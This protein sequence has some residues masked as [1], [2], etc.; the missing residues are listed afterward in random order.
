METNNHPLVSV[1]IITYNSSETIIE[2]LESIKAQSYQNIELIISDDCSKDNTVEICQEWVEENKDRFVRTQIITVDQNTGVSTNLNRAEVACQGDWVKSIAGDDL[3]LPICIETYVEYVKKNPNVIYVFSKVEVFGG[4]EERRQR[5]IELG[6]YDFFS[7]SSEQQ[8][9]YLT[10]NRNCIYA[11]TAFY[12]RRRVDE[13]GI[14]NDERIPLLEDWP[15]WIR[16][17]QMGIKLHFIDEVLVK[18]RMSDNA[19]STSTHST[20]FMKSNALVYK[21]YC[22]KNDLKK[23]NKK[24]AVLRYLRGERFLHDNNLFWKIICKLYKILII[25]SW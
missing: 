13:L 23:G 16:L 3:L 1:P 11:M 4:T 25:H 8:Y 15:K 9:D 6:N 24:M 21:Y 10:L 18:Y 14:T 7:W 20:G 22:F 2:T 17:T 12:N 5:I 19:L